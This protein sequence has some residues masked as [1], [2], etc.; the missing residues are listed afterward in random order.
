MTWDAL[1]LKRKKVMC[2]RP[3]LEDLTWMDELGCSSSFLSDH[4]Y[5]CENKAVEQVFI[6]TGS[7][8]SEEVGMI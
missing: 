6:D 5:Y 4:M 1:I 3:S 2:D 7:D 8:G